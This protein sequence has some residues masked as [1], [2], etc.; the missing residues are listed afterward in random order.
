MY[1]R[2]LLTV[3]K[4]TDRRIDAINK[5]AIM[6][7]INFINASPKSM[8][9]IVNYKIIIPQSTEIVNSFSAFILQLYYILL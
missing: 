1:A 3:S 8:F 5:D 7:I 2:F 9:V 4:A 6:H